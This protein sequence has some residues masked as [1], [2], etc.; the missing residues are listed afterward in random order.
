MVAKNDRTFTSLLAGHRMHSTELEE[1]VANLAKIVNTKQTLWVVT[2]HLLH[3]WTVGQDTSLIAA[4]TRVEEKVEIGIGSIDD[5]KCL[6][7]S[8]NDERRFNKCCKLYYHPELESA[9][10]VGSIKTISFKVLNSYDSGLFGGRSCLHRGIGQSSS[11]QLLECQPQTRKRE[12]HTLQHQKCSAVA[13]EKRSTKTRFWAQ[14][15]TLHL[16]S[17]HTLQWRRSASMEAWLSSVIISDPLQNGASFSSLCLLN[18][19]FRNRLY[20]KN[21]TH[22]MI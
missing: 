6:F 15:G 18:S 8:I 11:L 22:H 10:I 7:F 17:L 16:Q 12:K 19:I 14:D 1:L 2:N 9:L 5:N 21:K 3:H 4:L 20:F 13:A